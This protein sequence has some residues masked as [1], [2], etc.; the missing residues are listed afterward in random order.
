M[1]RAAGRAPPWEGPR[2][3]SRRGRPNPPTQP[4][5]PSRRQDP[6]QD[7]RNALL[8]QGHK[9]MGSPPAASHRPHNG[10]THSPT[11]RSPDNV[12]RSTSKELRTPS[13]HVV[14]KV[15]ATWDAGSPGDPYAGPH[16]WQKSRRAMAQ[17]R[18]KTGQKP[19]V[20]QGDVR[21]GAPEGDD[22]GPGPVADRTD[23]KKEPLFRRF[24]QVGQKKSCRARRKLRRG[25]GRRGWWP[26]SASPLGHAPRSR[27]TVLMTGE[28]EILC[29][30][31][32]VG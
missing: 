13:L 14:V 18:R 2:A 22:G 27:I 6:R 25:R 32:T 9:G 30:G 10:P 1:G 24:T 26:G 16:G 31:R 3:Q 28:A 19:A 15:G 29:L 4:T 20:G 7:P 11:T 8:S 21:P 5:Q 12:L 23:A 17:R